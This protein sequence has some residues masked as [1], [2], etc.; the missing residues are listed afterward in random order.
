[1]IGFW[2]VGASIKAFLLPPLEAAGATHEIH[3]S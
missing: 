2:G 1:M 3:S